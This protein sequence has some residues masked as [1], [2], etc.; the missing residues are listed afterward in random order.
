M[1]LKEYQK[2]AKRTCA[3]LDS[4]KLD[5]AHMVI[6]INTEIVELEEAVNNSDFVNIQEEVS[7]IIWYLA[8]YCTFRNYNLKDLHISDSLTFVTINNLYGKVSLL[9]DLVKKF[10]AYNKEIDDEKELPLLKEIFYICRMFL[11]GY[12]LNLDK[13]LENNINKLKVR[14]PEKFTE[15]NAINRNLTEERKELEK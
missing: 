6:G 7:D 14:F 5:L 13:G 10:V 4:V 12:S 11:I 9:Q 1:I 15:E 8:N 2:Q 3:P